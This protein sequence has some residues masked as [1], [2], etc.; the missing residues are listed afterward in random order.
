MMRGGG[1]RSVKY[2]EVIIL[3]AAGQDLLRDEGFETMVPGDRSTVWLPERETRT[4]EG[5]VEGFSP[6]SSLISRPPGNPLVSC[7]LIAGF[8]HNER[9]L[10]PSKNTTSY[11]MRIVKSHLAE[12]GSLRTVVNNNVLHPLRNCEMLNNFHCEQHRIL[13]ALHRDSILYKGRAPVAQ[14]GIPTSNK[15]SS[16]RRASSLKVFERHQCAIFLDNGHTTTTVTVRMERSNPRNLS[17]RVWVAVDENHSQMKIAFG[18][19]FEDCVRGVKLNSRKTRT[20]SSPKSRLGFIRRQV[21]YRGSAVGM[22]WIE[23][24]LPAIRSLEDHVLIEQARIPRQPH[25]EDPE[26]EI[27]PDYTL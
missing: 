3:V 2:E 23:S 4:T 8:I 11:I 27:I 26:T 7:Q 6:G 13:I 12:V 25:L 16:N 1:R 5:R 14:R 21:P 9:D 15:L 24:N 20:H 18:K 17:A 19:W 10:Q 22:Q